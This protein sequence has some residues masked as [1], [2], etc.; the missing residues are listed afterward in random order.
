MNQQQFDMYMQYGYTI[1]YFDNTLTLTDRRWK[2]KFDASVLKMSDLKYALKHYNID[3]LPWYA[4]FRRHND[5]NI[6]VLC[7][8]KIG[9][10]STTN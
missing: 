1:E 7:S 2:Y 9:M 8:T 4:K 5:T 3:S 6:Y 10:A